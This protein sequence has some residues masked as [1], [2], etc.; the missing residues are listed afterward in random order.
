MSININFKSPDAIVRR[1]VNLVCQGNSRDALTVLTKIGFDD[2]QKI[3]IEKAFQEIES[4][5]DA[6]CLHQCITQ[7]LRENIN[8]A[9]HQEAWS[10][11]PST[12]RFPLTSFILRT[13]P[14]ILDTIFCNLF[15]K[16]IL[17]CGQSCKQ[18][19]HA[20]RNEVIWEKI[21]QRDFLHCYPLKTPFSE[22]FQVYKKRYEKHKN[23]QNSVYS[24]NVL[25]N[26]NNSISCTFCDSEKLYSGCDGGVIKVW[27]LKTG[28][29]SQIL[30]GTEGRVTAIYAV[31][32][33]IY[34]GSCNGNITIWDLE[35]GGGNFVTL[36]G[37]GMVKA[38]AVWNDKLYAGFGT[39]AIKIW[40]LKTQAFLKTLR[41]SGP[42]I[43]SF[44]IDGSKLYLGSQESSI[45]IWD[46]EKEVCLKDAL[47]GHE[48]GVNFLA[49]Y[50]KELYSSSKDGAVRRWNLEARECRQVFKGRGNSADNL[51]FLGDKMFVSCW[52]QIQVWSIET[53]KVLN[54]LPQYNAVNKLVVSHGKL[55]L[56]GDGCAIKV[57]AFRG[58]YCVILEQI[59]QLF[60]NNHDNATHLA[61]L[62]FSGMSRSRKDRVFEEL[63]SIPPFLPN[64]CLENLDQRR[65]YW[66]NSPSERR[67]Q[68]IENHLAKNK[69]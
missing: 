65:L 44:V 7:I 16:D 43:N 12:S 36:S 55:Y 47:E 49:V 39:G 38:F 19:N 35:K 48:N 24:L 57:M 64:L 37:G 4:R 45:Q 2:V 53:G 1:A 54:T 50:G 17:S 14:E 58:D 41:S 52:N 40:D 3:K 20:T 23:I 66:R 15:A 42:G 63:F 21:Y 61:E 29:C 22:V 62:R 30:N 5:T 27:D 32:G 56:G 59:A 33:K 34:S 28:N 26:H 13:P 10:K 60:R 9:L 11:T 18:L 46:L 69:A 8:A 68:A 6:P 25:G 51:A 31:G 67:A